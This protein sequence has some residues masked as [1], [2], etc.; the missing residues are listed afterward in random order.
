MID[1]LV[2]AELLLL[3]LRVSVTTRMKTEPRF[4]WVCSDSNVA[5]R[6][7]SDLALPMYSN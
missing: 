2:L 7:L 4:E 1:L 3:Y 5:F 6:F